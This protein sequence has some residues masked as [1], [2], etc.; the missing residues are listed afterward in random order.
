MPSLAGKAAATIVTDLFVVLSAGCS[1]LSTTVPILSTRAEVIF[2][3]WQ[4]T[5]CLCVTQ[6]AHGELP[7]HRKAETVPS[8][9]TEPVCQLRFV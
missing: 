1:V 5:T 2:S 3:A 4:E 9:A 7:T 8:V 6:P